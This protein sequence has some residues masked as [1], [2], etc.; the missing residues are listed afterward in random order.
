LRDSYSG[1]KTVRRDHY[2]SF[3]KFK[4]GPVPI[5]NSVLFQSVKIKFGH[6]PA[7]ENIRS[8]SNS[9][10]NVIRSHSGAQKSIRSHSVFAQN[11]IW[12]HSDWPFGLSQGCQVADLSAIF[13]DFGRME[14]LLAEWKNS[15]RPLPKVA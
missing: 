12:S 9:A 4:F 13:A 15:I 10:Q 3:P 14:K 11:V 8:P 2:C 6:V 1:R 7:L 5:R